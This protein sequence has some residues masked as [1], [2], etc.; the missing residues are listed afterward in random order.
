MRQNGGM[1]MTCQTTAMCQENAPFP[2]LQV[3]HMLQTILIIEN[4]QMPFKNFLKIDHL[5]C[6]LNSSTAPKNHHLLLMYKVTF[7]QIF[8]KL[9]KMFLESLQSGNSSVIHKKQRKRKHET[10]ANNDKLH[11]SQVPWR[12]ETGLLRNDEVS[13]QTFALFFCQCRRESQSLVCQRKSLPSSHHISMYLM[14]LHSLLLVHK[15]PNQ[16]TGRVVHVGLFFFPLSRKLSQ[17]LNFQLAVVTISI[18]TFFCTKWWQFVGLRHFASVADCYHPTVSTIICYSMISRFLEAMM[19]Q[20]CVFTGNA[21]MSQPQMWAT[22]MELLNPLIWRW[23]LSEKRSKVELVQLSLS[24]SWL[25]I[26]VTKQK[27]KKIQFQIMRLQ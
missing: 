25:S 6:Q 27:Y 18:L 23:C 22:H 20:C 19:D 13:F 24:L 12:P 2:G 8:D 15:I 10:A 11:V 17:C 16:S 1:K 5:I 7:I 3:Q 9:N 21:P 4:W 26:T 14:Y